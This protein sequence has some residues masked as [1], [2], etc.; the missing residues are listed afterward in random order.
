MYGLSLE[1]IT[2]VVQGKLIGEGTQTEPVGAAID[3]RNLNTGELFFALIGEKADGHTFVQEA[4]NK[5]AKAA[6]VSRIPAG[7]S[8]EKFPLIIVKDTQKALQ[9]TAIAQRKL[10]L[11]PVIAVTG[12]TG[13]TTTKDLLA[14]ILSKRGPVLKTQGNYNNELGLPL[15]ILSLKKE[16]W[17]M[18]LEMG[19]RALGEID[20]LSRVSEPNFGIITNIGHTHQECLGSQEKIAQAKAELISHLPFDGG[21]V[22]SGDDY[23]HLRPW[24]SNSRCPITWVGLQRKLDLWASDIN[25]A[26]TGLSFQIQEKASKI[27]REIKLPLLGRHNVKNA[28]LAF[29]SARQVGLFWEEIEKGLKDVELTPMRLEIKGNAAHDLLIIDDAYNANPDSMLAALEVLVSLGNTRRK[30]SVLGDMYELGNYTQAAH[31]LV[32]KK[33]KELDITYLITVGELASII[34]QSAIEAGMS[35]KKIRTCHDNEE[36][37]FYL[38]EIVSDGDIILVKGSRGVKM[39]QIVAGLSS[40]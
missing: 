8:D 29:A 12:S 14:G 31:Q 37:L 2:T 18:V 1:Q 21:L 23:Q 30:I 26:S 36:A 4:I 20:F 19:M 17:A 35:P 11:G 10:F 33:T 40:L 39:E 25:Q 5:G 6:V 3:S 34:A 32:G 13:K 22:V 24:L 9:Q 15:T 7:I 28:L 27:K 38:K 16:H